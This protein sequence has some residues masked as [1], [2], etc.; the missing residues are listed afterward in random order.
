[1]VDL[2]WPGR[3]LTAAYWLLVVVRAR[4]VPCLDSLDGCMEKATL[5]YPEKNALCLS[6]WLQFAR[7][8]HRKTLTN[9]GQQT[10]INDSA[11][12][13]VNR[14]IS[15]DLPSGNWSVAIENDHRNS[16]C[17]PMKTWW[18]FKAT[19]KK[20]HFCRYIFH[21]MEHGWK[22]VCANRRSATPSQWNQRPRGL[23][24]HQNKW[25]NYNDDTFMNSYDNNIPICL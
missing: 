24:H 11:M 2:A 23:R 18:F 8:K 1:M 25:D 7:E 4:Y 3:C 17:L 20:A 10:N 16:W 12:P 5:R 22:P 14:N 21:S 13:H 6:C 9:C 19:P 15:P